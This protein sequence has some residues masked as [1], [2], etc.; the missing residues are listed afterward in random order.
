MVPELSEWTIVLVGQWNPHIFSAKWIAEELFSSPGISIEAEMM[1]APTISTPRYSYDDLIISPSIHRL[2]VGV[3]KADE[4][5]LTK[6]ESLAVKVLELLRHTPIRGLGINFAFSEKDLSPEILRIFNLPD[7]PAS[8]AAGIEKYTDTEIIRK[9]SHL[10]RELNIKIGL[11]DNSA[12]FK[13]HYNF[14][15]TGKSA[16]NTKENLQNSVVKFYNESLRL[17]SK[18]YQLSL[19]TEESDGH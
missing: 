12:K 15:K 3:K 9:V 13:I 10:D 5:T 17:S 4:E 16:D 1:I 18:V 19:S 11:S 6:A 14:H 7:T 2:I 8:L